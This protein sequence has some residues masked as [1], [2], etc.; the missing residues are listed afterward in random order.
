VL[1]PVE[2]VAVCGESVDH[3]DVDT[4]D[5]E[6]PERVGA[7]GGQSGDQIDCRDGDPEPARKL[8]PSEDAETREHLKCTDDEDYPSPGPEVVEDELVSPTKK[9][10]RSMAA[11]PQIMFSVPRTMIM[12][13]AKVSQPSPV[14][15]P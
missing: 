13:P 5:D 11:M 10:E 8:V 3:E 9:P 2:P 1:A 12:M 14:R 4:D 7:D 15:L 6:R